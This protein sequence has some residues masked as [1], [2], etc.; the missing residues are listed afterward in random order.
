M[1]FEFSPIFVYCI[2]S[3]PLLKSYL[4]SSCFVYNLSSQ[5]YILLVCVG[6]ESCGR[7]IPQFINI[8]EHS[9]DWCVD[10]KTHLFDNVLTLGKHIKCNFS[11]AIK[12][13]IED[14]ADGHLDGVSIEIAQDSDVIN[15]GRCDCFLL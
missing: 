2:F 6:I 11:V 1:W 10:I 7:D 14:D 13:M 4:V 3:T 12:Y 15:V 9:I 5:V 8:V